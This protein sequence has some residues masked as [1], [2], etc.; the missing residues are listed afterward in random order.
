[1]YWRRP[2]G[3]DGRRTVNKSFRQILI[4][5]D[6]PYKKG[7]NVVRWLPQSSKLLYVLGYT[8]LLDITVRGGADRSQ[9]KSYDG[10]TPVGPWL[11]TGYEIG[12]PHNLRIRLWL[13][14]QPQPRQM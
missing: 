14:G 2:G 13:E 11:V 9:R 4:L 6:R 7:V 8:G 12:D 3:R 10:F 1:M 5:R